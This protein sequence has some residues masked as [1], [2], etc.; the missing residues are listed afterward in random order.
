[1]KFLINR[2]EKLGGSIVIPG[3]KSGTARALVIGAMGDG[4][5]TVVNPLHNIDTYSIIDCLKSFGIKF[6]LSDDNKWI[7]YG[8]GGVLEQPKK[9][10]DVGNSGTGLY[11]II[12]LASLFNGANVVSGDYQICYRSAGPEVD[13]L[14][15]M[16]A[17]IKSTRNNGLAPFYIEGGLK[18]GVC[19]MPNTN[20]QWYNLG[21]FLCCA[22]ADGDS[23]IRIEGT[24]YERPYVDMSLGMLQQAGIVIEN[25]DYKKFVIK[26]HQKVKATEFVIPGDWGSS[27]Y[28]TVAAA[29]T[30]SEVAFHNLDPN[31]YA[32]ETQNVD[33]LRNA[34]CKV[35]LTKDGIIV[36]GSDHLVGQEIDCTGTPDAVP[37]YA[38]LG[39][40]AKEGK[41]VLNNIAA[42]RL[43]E[44]DRTHTI[45]TELSKMGGKFEEENNRLIIYPSKLHG[46]FIDGHHDHRI[47]MASSI[48]ALIADGPSI[49]DNSEFSG[50]S[51]PEFYDHMKAL[52]ANIEKLDVVK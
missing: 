37:I 29:I 42:S 30:G 3:N 20:S 31:T 10:L 51:Y 38:V 8:K 47:V 6:D 41:T 49:I 15:L 33:V 16:G 40:A 52:G 39:L 34:G 35:D 48:A 32:G 9:V 46:T 14:N 12:A 7:V 13:A 36:K 27:G 1:M 17:K 45:V 43:K 18:G 28:P 21:M 4:P 19:T 2:T 25:Y 24:P 11:A 23:E 26:G 50:V 5:T 22:L 44:T